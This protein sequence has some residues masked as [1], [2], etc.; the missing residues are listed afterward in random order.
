MSPIIDVFPHPSSRRFAAVR[1]AVGT[2]GRACLR[3]ASAIRNRRQVMRLLELD[4]RALKDIGLVRNDVAGVLDT[5]LS[6]DPS[7][8]LRL[9]SVERRA[10]ARP[11]PLHA[12]PVTSEPCP[13][14]TAPSG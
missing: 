8:F 7:I 4:D 6:R 2:A 11:V 13:S 10:R 3:L 12:R 5:P 9:R 1:R 14:L